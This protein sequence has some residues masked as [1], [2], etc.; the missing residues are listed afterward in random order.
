MTGEVECHRCGEP[1]TAHGVRGCRRYGCDCAET[2]SS[3]A[4]QLAVDAVA[5]TPARVDVAARALHAVRYPLVGWETLS[6]EAMDRCRDEARAV[7][8]AVALRP[9][10][11]L[12]YRRR[13]L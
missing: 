10:P 3:I 4:Q 6:A 8:E 2:Q 9:R 12:T 11:N 7:L 1:I 13:N 5:V